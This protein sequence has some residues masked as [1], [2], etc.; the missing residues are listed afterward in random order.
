ML[1]SLTKQQELQKQAQETLKQKIYYSPLTC[2][3]ALH[4]LTQQTS[5]QIRSMNYQNNL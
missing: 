1:Y 4:L 2:K 5:F 3:M